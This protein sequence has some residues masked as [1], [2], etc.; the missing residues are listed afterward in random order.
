M[1]LHQITINRAVILAGIILFSIACLYP[2]SAADYTVVSRQMHSVQSAQT[3]QMLVTVT[4]DPATYTP[5]SSLTIHVVVTLNQNPY[6]TS[7]PVQISASDPQITITTHSRAT[8]SS[9][10]FYATLTTSSSTSGVIHVQAQASDLYCGGISAAPN[11][12]CTVTSAEGSVDIP[13]QAG[14]Q[15]FIQTKQQQSE[16]QSN[17]PPVQPASYQ[18]PVNQPPVNQPQ[19]QAVNQPPVAVISVDK[20]AGSAPLTVNF[21]ARKSY[22]PSGSISTYAW[23]FGDGSSNNGYVAQHQYS[24]PGTY[25]ASLVVMDNNELSSTPATT[26]ITV[27]SPIAPIV[28][29]V[30]GPSCDDGN[31]CTVNDHYDNSGNCVAGQPLNCDDNNPNTVDT[32]NPAAGC[33]HTPTVSIQPAVVQADTGMVQKT[34]TEGQVAAGLASSQNEL[35]NLMAKLNKGEQKYDL[36]YILDINRPEALNKGTTPESRQ[37]GAPQMSDFPGTGIPGNQGGQGGQHGNPLTS[38]GAGMPGSNLNPIEGNPYF[39]MPGIQNKY[40]MGM[41][42]YFPGMAGSVERQYG[43]IRQG[44]GPGFA[45]SGGGGWQ[46]L[47]G[48]AERAQDLKEAGYNTFVFY[49]CDGTMEKLVYTYEADVGGLHVTETTTELYFKGGDTIYRKEER[50]EEDEANVYLHSPEYTQEK[51]TP[52]KSGGKYE[53][54]EGGG[55][56]PT[57]GYTVIKEADYELIKQLMYSPPENRKEELAPWVNPGNKASSD[58]QSGTG[59]SSSQRAV[60]GF[61]IVRHGYFPQGWV[62]FQRM[63]LPDPNPESNKARTAS[64]DVYVPAL[65]LPDPVPIL[66]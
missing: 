11:Q 54:P 14:T 16:Q 33:V 49:A 15:Q 31:P 55:G 58:T 13:Q 9:G 36:Y 21:D 43:P 23:N 6:P 62:P 45:S 65:L 61:M 27:W 40:A 26:Q 59:Q 10:S 30:G 4:A 20:Y 52:P 44:L 41:P 19:Q 60:E 51:V 48:R 1:H 47:A 18:P 8:D 46:I 12:Q 63:N 37:Q 50:T 17:P 7:I 25:T 57:S 32:C 64:S 42:G 35:A 5:G 34:G 24:T 28:Y 66:G 29:N 39:Q 3:N 53:S 56:E 2:C 38:S 22:A